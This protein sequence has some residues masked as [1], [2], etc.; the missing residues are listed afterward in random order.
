LKYAEE[1]IEWIAGNEDMEIVNL[2]KLNKLDG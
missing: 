1:L 2:A